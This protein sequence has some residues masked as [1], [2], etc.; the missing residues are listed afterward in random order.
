MT[1]EK[2]KAEKRT[3]LGKKVKKLRKEGV[4]AANV[5]GKNFASTPIQVQVAEF[6]DVF[7]KA[8][9]TGVVDLTIED[10]TVPT[11]IHGLQIDPRSQKVIHADFL[12]VNLKEKITTRVSVVALDEAPAVKDKKGVLLNPLSDL[13][14]EALPTDLPEK[15]EVN[16]E[17]L[18]EVDD[19]ITVEMITTPAGVAILN[20][21]QQTVFKIGALVTQEAEELAEAEAEQAE[22]AAEAAK[23]AEEGQESTETAPTEEEAK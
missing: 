6:I 7:K 4:L 19:Q 10:K 21:P 15:I 2:I 22:E 13:E 9:E 3:L 12:K 17:R 11:L 18:Q 1:R 8:G 16:V 23:T 14:V 20:D 5:Y